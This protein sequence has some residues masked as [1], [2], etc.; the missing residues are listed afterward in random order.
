MGM[1]LELISLSWIRTPQRSKLSY[2]LLRCDTKVGPLPV[3][4]TPMFRVHYIKRY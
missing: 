1:L 2:A 4:L 3:C